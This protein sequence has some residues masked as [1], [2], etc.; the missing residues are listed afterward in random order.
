[1]S[2]IR[3]ILAESRFSGPAIEYR[4]EEDGTRTITRVTPPRPPWRLRPLSREERLC[5]LTVTGSW[6]E[7]FIS[8][9]RVGVQPNDNGPE[10]RL[11]GQSA[12]AYDDRLIPG[13]FRTNPT[14]GG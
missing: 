3:R 4:T 5:I 9:W 7:E 8:D 10:G 14:E 13:T 11:P 6:P 1:M 2:S 12:V